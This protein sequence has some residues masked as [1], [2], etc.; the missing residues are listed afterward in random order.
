MIGWQKMRAYEDVTAVD[1]FSIQKNALEGKTSMQRGIS[2]NIGNV[3]HWVQ[4]KN[5]RWINER[6]CT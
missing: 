4:E 3:A 1:G 6:S 2:S 5:R